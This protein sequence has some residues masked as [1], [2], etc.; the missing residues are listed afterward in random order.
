[1]R[2]YTIELRVDYEDESTYDLTL[3][4]VRET[5][6]QM[7]TVAMLMKEKRPPRMSVTA[8]DMFEVSDEKGMFPEHERPPVPDDTSGE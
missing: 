3:E 7:M 4:H 2:T 8:G 5:A 1:M 6:R